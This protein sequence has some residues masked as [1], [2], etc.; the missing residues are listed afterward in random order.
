M[1]QVATPEAD[2]VDDHFAKFVRPLGNLVV[3]FAQA[4]VEWLRLASKLSGCT[5][6]DAQRFLDMK[7]DVKEEITSLAQRC[8]N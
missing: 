1:T 6:K 4:E 8:G 5:E 7:P 3:L 2:L